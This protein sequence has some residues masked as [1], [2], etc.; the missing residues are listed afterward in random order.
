MLA[1]ICLWWIGIQ[2]SA[3]VWFYAIL[4]IS[5]ISR[6]ISFGMKMFQLGKEN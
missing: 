2:L 5:A 4:A 6:M 1:I 3:P